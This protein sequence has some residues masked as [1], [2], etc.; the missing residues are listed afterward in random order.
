MLKTQSATPTGKKDS[1]SAEK[2]ESRYP[3]QDDDI[4]ARRLN[5]L[6]AL[7]DDHSIAWLSRYIKAGNNV[8]EI[9]PG[10]GQ[11]ATHVLDL[12]GDTGRYVGIEA[13]KKRVEK[14]TSVL[15]DHPNAKVMQADAIVATAAL[16]EAEAQFDVIYF[17]WFLWIVP[18]EQRISFLA[19]LFILLKPG[20]VILAEEAD[21]TT[22]SSDPPHSGIEQHKQYTA[23]RCRSG[24]HPLAL[25]PEMPS[26][27]KQA[28]P[29][30]EISDPESFQ[31]QSTDSELKRLPLFGAIS[32]RASLTGAGLKAV[33]LDAN[34]EELEKMADD[35][36][37]T[38]RFTTNYCTAARLGK[39]R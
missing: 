6:S 36:A 20:G 21:I 39:N 19:T 23:L 15:K 11:L 1:S 2:E 31:P 4:E 29:T 5:A 25:G 33:A 14:T 37:T 30:A 35:E 38:L 3:Y 16:S 26:L 13:N 18:S 12:I 27:F 22:L 10:D 28:Q 7:Y 8:L 34:I 32:A 17:R 24:G 9:G